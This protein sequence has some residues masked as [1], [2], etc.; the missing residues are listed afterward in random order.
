MK[1]K[2]KDLIRA[3]IRQR[4]KLTD[5]VGEHPRKAKRKKREKREAQLGRDR[6]NKHTAK[7]GHDRQRKHDSNFL[8]V[9]FDFTPRIHFHTHTLFC[10]SLLNFSTSP[11]NV[12]DAS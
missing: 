11:S 8:K 7:T 12:D 6:N 1:R 2:T 3:S 10:H 9:C 5:E 4:S